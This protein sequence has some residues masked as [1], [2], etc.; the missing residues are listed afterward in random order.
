MNRRMLSPQEFTTMTSAS[1]KSTPL[2]FKPSLH[3]RRS[4]RRAAQCSNRQHYHQSKRTNGPQ[5]SP[6]T[7]S[8]DHNTAF[9]E[10]LFDAMADCEGAK[11]WEGVYGQPIHQF[12]RIY[13]GPDGET[14]TMSD[15]EFVTYAR[16]EMWKTSHAGLQEELHRKRKAEQARRRI[17]AETVRA[18]AEQ[19]K[20]RTRAFRAQREHEALADRV[21]A[22][23]RKGQEREERKTIFEAVRRY[24][25]GWADITKSSAKFIQVPWPTLSG[26]VEDVTPREV[27]VFL[28]H[29]S[30]STQG[31]QR[32][33]TTLKSE[34]V[35]W[36][37]DKIQQRAQGLLDCPM[38]EKV[39]AVFQIIDDLYVKHK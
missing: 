17:W 38:M 26:S 23:L 28:G 1:P 37:P 25:K 31:R 13:T 34:R 9:R 3:S 35:K 19:H 30:D 12:S 29:L 16:A 39:T 6:P 36:H 5:P 24:E 2:R 7:Q 22:S 27:E 18:R 10:S 11:Y 21:A 33:I 4:D 15:E 20:V 8:I 14:H 32:L